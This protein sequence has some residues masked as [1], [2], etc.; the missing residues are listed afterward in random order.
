MAFRKVCK[1]VFRGFDFQYI[2]N[3]VHNDTQT[4]SY[5]CREELIGLFIAHWCVLFIRTSLATVR[6]VGGPYSHRTRCK[7]IHHPFTVTVRTCFLS[8]WV[9]QLLIFIFF[10]CFSCFLFFR[11]LRYT[12][13]STN[14]FKAFWDVSITFC[15]NSVEI[16]QNSIYFN[17]R[18]SWRSFNIQNFLESSNIV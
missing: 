5:D 3:P 15:L 8:L 6:M 17:A 7:K 11:V 9:T 14:I 12:M 1:R 18:C 16:I 2:T 4:G 13:T 10:F